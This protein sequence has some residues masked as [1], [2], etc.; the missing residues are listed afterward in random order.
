MCSFLKF[1]GFTL[2]L[3]EVQGW[4]TTHVQQNAIR[5]RPKSALQSVW[6]AVGWLYLSPDGS[7]VGVV[8]WYPLGSVQTTWPV[9]DAFYRSC[10]KVDENLAPGFDCL[11]FP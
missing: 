9:C 5:S 4:K 11:R 6:T 3:S 10:V 2:K 7:G 1:A 8:F